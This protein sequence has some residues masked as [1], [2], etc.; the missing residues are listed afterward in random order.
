MCWLRCATAD[1]NP[2]DPLLT[3]GSSHV[4]RGAEEV[5]G[6]MLLIRG[7]AQSQTNMIEFVGMNG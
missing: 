3:N 7:V 4:S 6:M 5:S 1:M 2:K